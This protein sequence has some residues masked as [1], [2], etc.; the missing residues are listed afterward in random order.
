MTT[1]NGQ[2]PVRPGESA[3][4]FT[5]PAVHQDRAI[6]LADYRGTP[7]FL[8]LFLGLWC[9]FCRRNIAQLGSTREKLLAQGVETLAV[10]A[11]ELDNARLY[12]KYRPVPVPLVAD[13]ALLTHRAYR[14][15]RPQLDEPTLHALASTRINPTGELPAPVPVTEIGPLLDRADNFQRTETD[16]KD[17]DKQ[18]PSLR[19]QFLVDRDSIVRWSNIECE[20]DGIAGIGAFPS[21]DEVL[22]A[23]REVGITR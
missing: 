14:L 7:V 21:T 11:T 15:P 18:W 3:P 16:A 6:S 13:P 10:V 9:P 17:L 12:F 22:A 8:A 5:L 20:H 19:A 1:T 2:P 23:T 4:G